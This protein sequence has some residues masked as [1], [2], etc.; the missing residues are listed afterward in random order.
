M[1]TNEAE[2]FRSRGALAHGQEKN[3]RSVCAPVR[4]HHSAQA[5]WGAIGGI[6]EK[7]TDICQDEDRPTLV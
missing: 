7:V 1:G 5:G 2:P 3:L 6:L 4:F